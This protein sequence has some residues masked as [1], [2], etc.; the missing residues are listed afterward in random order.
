MS[1]VLTLDFETRDPSIGLGRGAGWV[2]RDFDI[3]GMA[4]QIEDGPTHW[5]SNTQEIK[6]LVHGSRTLVAHNAQ[7]DLGCL[8]RLGILFN[9]KLCVDTLILAKLYDNTGFR[10]SLDRLAADFLGD[11]KDYS[12][13]ELAAAE[14]GV[15]KPRAHIAEL[16]K[17]RPDLVIKYAKQDVSLTYRL[18]QWFKAEMYEDM[19]ALIPF[20]SDLLKALVKW[21][22]SGV[23]IDLAQA[24]KSSAALSALEQDARPAFTRY[25]GDINIESTEQLAEA[26][27]ALGLVVGVSAKGGPSVDA[28]WRAT[29]THPAVEALSDAKRYKKLRREFVDGLWDRAE[30]GKIYPEI[31]ILGATETGRMSSSNPNIQQIPKRD[32]LA[33]SLIR[34]LFV[35][36]PGEKVY[37]LDFS[38]QEPR[39]QVHYAYLA[40]SPGASLLREAFLSNPQHD[41]HQQVADL[42]QIDRKTAKTINLGISYGMGIAKLATTL[43]LNEKEASKLLSQYKTLTPYLAHLSKAVQAAGTRKGYIRTLLGRHLVMDMEKPYKALN[44]LIQGSAADQTSMA[45]VQAYREGIDIKFAVHD[46]L[47]LTTTDPSKAQRLK[48]IME[49]VAPLTVPSYVGISEGDSWGG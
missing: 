31:N 14:V 10:Y 43:K 5:T 11:R 34:S 33:T 49:T 46:E 38:S 6:D 47:V 28:A 35:G 29:Q 18:L 23:R 1:Y 16:Y 44:K 2:Y 21:R 27:T 48:E 22:S 26:L 39:L 30:N 13:L 24:E 37:S 8:S 41:L 42:A 12:S 32:E 25:C 15:K 36:E 17:H 19:K 4:Y 3:L 7:Y 45:M 20:Y 40:K 9:D